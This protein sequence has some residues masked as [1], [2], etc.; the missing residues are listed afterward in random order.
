MIYSKHYAVVPEK[1]TSALIAAGIGTGKADWIKTNLLQMDENFIV[2]DSNGDYVKTVGNALKENGYK[3]QVLNL[4]EPKKG[5]HYNPFAYDFE[6][7]R[8]QNLVDAILKNVKNEKDD[9]YFYNAERTLLSSVMAYILEFGKEQKWDNMLDFIHLVE[10]LTEPEKDNGFFRL[11]EDASE[12]SIAKRYLDSF[13]EYVGD[14]TKKSVLL[15]SVVDMQ[16][17][18]TEEMLVCMNQDELCLDQWSEEKTAL[19]LVTHPMEKKNNTLLSIFFCQLFSLLSK[20][21]EKWKYPVHCIMDEF[22]SCGVIPNLDDAIAYHGDRF[23]LSLILQETGHMAERYN[24]MSSQYLNS[25]DDCLYF[26]VSDDSSLSYFSERFH[27]PIKSLKRLKK[28]RCIL[29]QSDWKNAIRDK[30]YK[31]KKSPAYKKTADYKAT[32]L[33]DIEFMMSN[34][35][36]L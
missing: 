4:K 19:F 10:T 24:G 27:L 29:L 2:V 17:L 15:S 12:D 5:V 26:G 32:F 22:M 1:S 36:L 34:R 28:N 20:E 18:F 25:F 21:S 6:D 9:G 14:K 16:D 3:V 35:K 23:H 8:V 33:Y 13:Q 11:M 30:R 31:Y 7:S